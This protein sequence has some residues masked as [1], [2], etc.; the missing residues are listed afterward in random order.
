VPLIERCV[1]T[2]RGFSAIVGLGWRGAV[3]TG[4][5][6]MCDYSLINVAT[7]PARVGDRL[8]TALFAGTITRGFAAV[9]EP[10]VAVCLLPGTEI[11]FQNDIEF[12][13]G[14]GYLKVWK[15]EK[16]VGERLARFRMVNKDKPDVHHDA[17][18]L[19]NGDVVLVSRLCEGQY[20]TVLQLPSLHRA[21]VSDAEQKHVA[22]AV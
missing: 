1:M 8:V 9:D 7:R 20:A 3:T 21:P 16:R 15:H 2:A 14:L 17:I 4:A 12:E 10:N 19:V 11:A 18:E 22:P 5:P 13:G 6:A